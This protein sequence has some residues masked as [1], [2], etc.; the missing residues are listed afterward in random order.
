MSFTYTK[1]FIFLLAA[2]VLS[3]CGSGDDSDL[4]IP[5]TILSEEKFTKLIVD[6]S[7][8]ESA[9]NLNVK[10]FP[11]EKMDSAYAFDPL[12]ENKISKS[13]YDSAV[14]FYSKHPAI[15]K[16]IYE[17]VLATLSRMQL[18]NDS[19]KVDPISK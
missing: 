3:A 5:D 17:N 1:L 15:Y 8:A 12:E 11:A 6:F 19:A 4:T 9:S 18:R 7:L 2:I 13:Q 14:S 10:N 16:K